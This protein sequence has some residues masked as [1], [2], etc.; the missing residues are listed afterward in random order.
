MKA[1][2]KDLKKQ[3]VTLT[4]L[5][6]EVIETVDSQDALVKQLQVQLDYANMNNEQ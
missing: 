5:L 1:T 6:Q 3:I 4:T 2:K